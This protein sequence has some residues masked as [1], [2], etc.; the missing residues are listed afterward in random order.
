MPNFVY[1]KVDPSRLSNAAGNIDNSLNMLGNALGAIDDA[2]K[3]VLHPTWAGIASDQFFQQYALDNA[4]FSEHMKAL[5]TLNSQLREAAGIF[6][7]A[8][9]KADELVKNLK[10]V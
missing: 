3:S 7:K 6:D 2:L 8:D 1:T 5:H 4:A 10:T 9:G